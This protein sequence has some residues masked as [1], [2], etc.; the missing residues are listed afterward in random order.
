M[1]AGPEVGKTKC[2]DANNKI[3]FPV[4]CHPLFYRLRL[5][6][7]PPERKIPFSA[8]KEVTHA[9]LV[10]SGTCRNASSPPS[11]KFQVPC[12][13][14]KAFQ[15]FGSVVV[16]AIADVVFDVV[17]QSHV[18]NSFSFAFDTW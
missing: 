3:H 6:L 15:F 8:R 7:D 5:W 2:P 17:V 18:D 1:A 13:P 4:T 16:F 10:L 12:W 14:T 9:A 11:S